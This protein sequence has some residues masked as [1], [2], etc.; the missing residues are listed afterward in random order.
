[1]TAS[2]SHPRVQLCAKT[3]LCSVLRLHLP[4][5]AGG[6]TVLQYGELGLAVKSLSVA[7]DSRQAWDRTSGTK[8]Q[9]CTMVFGIPSPAFL[10]MPV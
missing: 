5:L 3:S 8:L 2:S 10:L 9:S 7:K 4:E 6:L 1:M